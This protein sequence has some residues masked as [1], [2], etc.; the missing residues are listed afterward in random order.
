MTT[1]D[2]SR[3]IDV[4]VIHNRNEVNR[5]YLANNLNQFNNR[6]VLFE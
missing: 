2:Y 5:R 3:W 6:G 1:L 4:R